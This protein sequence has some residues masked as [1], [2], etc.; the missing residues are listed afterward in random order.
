MEGWLTEIDLDREVGSEGGLSL[1]QLAGMVENLLPGGRRGRGKRWADGGGADL[2][3]SG[4][5]R[6]M[7]GLEQVGANGG[8]CD[9]EVA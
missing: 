5:M 1:N 4:P 9:G 2:D 7:G 3:F 6:K 8:Q